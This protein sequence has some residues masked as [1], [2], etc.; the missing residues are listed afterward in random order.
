M[1]ILLHTKTAYGIS[2]HCKLLLN[3]CFQYISSLSMQLITNIWSSSYIGPSF[4]MIHCFI[5]IYPIDSKQLLNDN[6]S[7][8]YE[9]FLLIFV[10]MILILCLLLILLLVTNIMFDDESCLFWNERCALNCFMLIQT[11]TDPCLM[12]HRHPTPTW[13]SLPMK[14]HH[15]F[16]LPLSQIFCLGDP[17]IPHCYNLT[18]VVFDANC[19]RR[20]RLTYQSVNNPHH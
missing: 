10:M 3:L 18:F 11:A 1:W 5:S 7:D 8:Y 14:S 2:C 17:H 15:L 20:Q 9:R 13:L 19:I 4:K 12:Q 16:A 6:I